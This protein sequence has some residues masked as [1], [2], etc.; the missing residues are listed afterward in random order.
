MNTALEAAR[1]T[2]AEA[3]QAYEQ[4]RRTGCQQAKQAAH[5]RRTRAEEAVFAAAYDLQ[6]GS[7]TYQQ[8]PAYHKP[9]CKASPTP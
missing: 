6:Q 1:A 8:R 3:E 9:R 4:A 5:Q 7:F 2:L